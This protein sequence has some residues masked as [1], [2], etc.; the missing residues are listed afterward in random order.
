MSKEDPKGTLVPPPSLMAGT[1]GKEINA[2]LEKKAEEQKQ[3]AQVTQNKPIEVSTPSSDR[4]LMDGVL[5]NFGDNVDFEGKRK[6]NSIVNKIHATLGDDYLNKNMDKLVAGVSQEIKKSQSFF[7]YLKSF[8]VKTPIQIPDSA[9][10]RVVTNV[11]PSNEELRKF[12]SDLVM[13][14]GKE[15]L[16]EHLKGNTSEI[17]RP[18]VETPK[19]ESPTL[20][21]KPKPKLVAPPSLMGEKENRELKAILEKKP[22]SYTEKVTQEKKEEKNRER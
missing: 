14:Q 17:E 1:Q 22:G 6:I 16:K 3:N 15:A 4:K 11:S 9:I 12:K 7:S 2:F 18:K 20:E 21:Q 5:K 13:A 19:V 8:F 10:D